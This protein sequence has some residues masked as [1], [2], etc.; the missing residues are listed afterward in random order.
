MEKSCTSPGEKGIRSSH[1]HTHDG[2]IFFLTC[3]ASLAVCCSLSQP[4]LG[5]KVKVGK[6]NSRAKPACTTQ[7]K[8]M[9]LYI[10]YRIEL[11]QDFTIEW[12]QN[13]AQTL[14]LSPF[15]LIHCLWREKK[16]WIFIRIKVYLCD[17]GQGLFMDFS[18]FF[19]SPLFRRHLYD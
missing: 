14:Q 11:F 6:A 5:K 9:L 16:W 8:K 10:W 15:Q 3:S 4:R 17:L 18:T 7:W 13:W 19:V 2:R 1:S 12:T